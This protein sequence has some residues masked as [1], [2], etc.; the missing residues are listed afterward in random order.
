MQRVMMVLMSGPMFLS[1]TA[2]L[3]SVKRLRS[4]PNCMDWS[5]GSKA[6]S[7][8]S[9]THFMTMDENCLCDWLSCLRSTCKSHSPPWS[10]MGQSS[11][12]L[13]R[14]N[15]ITPSLSGEVYTEK[16]ES[17]IAYPLLLT[18]KS[19][20]HCCHT[21]LYV[22]F[23]S[24]WGCSSPSWQAWHKQPQANFT[25]TK[26]N[27]E[28]AAESFCSL[29]HNGC[30]A[31]PWA[32]SRSRP[33]T[34]GS[35]QLPTDAHGSRTSGSEFQPSRKPG[36]GTEQVCQPAEGYD[37]CNYKPNAATGIPATRWSQPPPPLVSHRQKLQPCCWQ[38]VLKCALK[39]TDTYAQVRVSKICYFSGQDRHWVASLNIAT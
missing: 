26:E 37:T 18:N 4:E 8:S 3:P 9:R 31:L 39:S 35:F 19:S 30:A 24:W 10:Q 17:T 14:R 5:W 33:D 15:S 28:I 6:A 22:F 13:A 21:W 25:H 23:L 32:L 29:K 11:G 34:C 36:A 7:V 1:S 2:L 12:W 16:K 20:L 38:L 27:I